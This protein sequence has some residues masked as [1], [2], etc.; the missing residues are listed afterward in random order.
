MALFEV[1]A[2]DKKVWEEEL[3]DFLPDKILDCHTHVYKKE[4][5][6]GNASVNTERLVSWT[7]TVADENPI[8]DL[9]ET[10][11][12]MF[13]GKQVSALMFA[14]QNGR[15]K[16]NEY[17]AGAAKE[18]GWPA[19]Y[20]SHPSESADEL[21]AEIRK[22][23]FLG[24]K[25]YLALAPSYIPANEIRIF[26][27]FPKHQLERLNEM[28][29]ICMCHIPRSG[30]LKDQV[31]IQQI[32]E[33]RREF[34]N[35]RLIVAHVGRAYTKDDL[36]DAFDYL[37]QEPETMYDFCANCCDA[38]IEEV[39]KRCGVKHV[40][41]GTDMPIL[42]MR[43]H[44]IE[45]NG[46]YINLVPP[47]M[48]PDPFGDPHLREVSE[49]EAETITFFAYEELLSLKRVSEKLGLSKADIEDIMYNNAA[50]LIAGAKR[51]IY[52]K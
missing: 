35:V 42:R 48:Y 18:Y 50:N 20:Y 16:N 44:R 47:G 15:E 23:G 9:D 38:A 49:E 32:L 27:F 33:L 10:Y 41:F 12:L 8:E 2:Y 11:K 46:T 43:T 4:F 1:T 40:M 19:L 6:E 25:S 24:V 39:I 17:L 30:R 28:G 52:G 3:R 13:P 34:P 7:E 29:A 37:T 14:T 36:G 22:G 51:D 26:D 31:N 5:Y 45:E 21:E